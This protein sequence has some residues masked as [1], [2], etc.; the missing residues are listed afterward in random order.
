MNKKPTT[1]NEVFEQ[2]EKM[3]MDGFSQEIPEQVEFL[4]NC[5]KSANVK[6]IMEIGFNAGHSSELFLK[7]NP[8][9][10]V[11]SFDI[12]GY[13]CVRV[14]KA[15]ID[16]MFPNRHT[17]IKGNSLETV[18]QHEPEEN[19]K[20]DIIFIDGGHHYPI[21][22]GDLI[23]CRRLAHKDTIVILDDTVKDEKLICHWNKGPNQAWS[24]A[25]EWNVVVQDGYSD[26]GR[27]RGQSWGRYLI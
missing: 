13:N 2:R 27:G 21:A 14:G 15:F 18:P 9:V 26:F 16:E 24:E 12:C 10:K 17:L 8:D 23:N 3:N 7:T 20:Y 6:N 22:K 11:T 4:V 5:A 1:L 19:V 25:I